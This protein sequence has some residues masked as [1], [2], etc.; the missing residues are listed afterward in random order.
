[1]LEVHWYDAVSFQSEKKRQ[2]LDQRPFFIVPFYPS[3]Y[4]LEHEKI[5]LVSYN[6]SLR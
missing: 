1:M 6:L 5:L 2:K 4:A 3:G